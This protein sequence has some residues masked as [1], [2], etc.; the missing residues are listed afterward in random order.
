VLNRD[1]VSLAALDFGFYFDDPD[2]PVVVTPARTIGRE[3]RYV[4][5][6]GQLVAGSAYSAD[7][8]TAMLDNPGGEPWQFAE[9]VAK[10]LEPPEEVYVLDVCEAEGELKLL[11]LNPFSG[12]D[13]YGCSAH[14]VVKTVS[15]AAMR[16]SSDA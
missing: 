4:V 2:L 13:L 15:E 1:D 6:E 7:G 5:A 14:D 3:W 9:K 8:R 10:A 16:F 11:E 12:A